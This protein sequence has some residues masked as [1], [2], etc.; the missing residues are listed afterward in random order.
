MKFGAIA[1]H[2][3]EGAILAHSMAVEAKRIGKGTRLT[4]GGGLDWIG[5]RVRSALGHRIE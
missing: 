3:A 1:T 5:F 2:D 4:Q